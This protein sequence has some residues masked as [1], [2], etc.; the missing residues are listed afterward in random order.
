MSPVV[1]KSFNGEIKPSSEGFMGMPQSSI[2]QPDN[3]NSSSSQDVNYEYLEEVVVP[4]DTLKETVTNYP[5]GRSVTVKEPMP[6]GT[7]II[8]KSKSAVNQAVG[9]SWHDTA[10]EMSAALGSFQGVQYA[11]IAFLILGGVG[12]FHPV[13]RALIGGKDVAMALG[14]CGAIMMF[15]PFLFVQ[16]SQYFFLA[17]LAAGGYWFIA[18]F[19][20]KDGKL[21]AI[22]T[23]TEK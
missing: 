13:L 5:D 9:G 2:T 8:K 23:R 22:E 10:R 16:Y 19:K 21:D 14:G 17:I 4:I 15:G 6:A 11:G 1:T 20:Y 12:F 3:P 18:R 7:R